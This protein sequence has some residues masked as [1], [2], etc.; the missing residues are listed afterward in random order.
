MKFLVKIYFMLLSVKGAIV[1][2]LS[3]RRHR[4]CWC[5]KKLNSIEIQYYINSC[6]RCENLLMYVHKDA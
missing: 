5:G 3:S 6:D 2:A 4:C 1:R